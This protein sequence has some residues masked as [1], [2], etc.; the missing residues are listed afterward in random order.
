MS[1]LAKPMPSQQELQEGFDYRD[2]DFYRK[3][4]NSN[5]VKVGSKAGHVHTDKKTGIQY[6]KVRFNHKKYP[7]HRL[8][9]A[10][11]GYSLEP[12]Q[13]IDHI[14]G[15]SLNNHIENLRVATHKQNQE[16]RKGANKNSKTGVKGVREHWYK[17]TKKWR[18]EIQYNGKSKHLGL[19]ETKKDAI[20][21]R[22]AAEKEYYTH[23]PNR[24]NELVIEKPSGVLSFI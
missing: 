19:Y 6:I 14:D 11:H 23:A 21:A 7:I 22:I 9:W 8:I 15:N 13:Q 2:G 17:S 10:W 24:D 16:N 12:N 20:A 5:N 3:K 4:A 1:K 18:A